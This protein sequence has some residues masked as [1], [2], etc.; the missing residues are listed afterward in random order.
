MNDIEKQI[1]EFFDRCPTRKQIHAL[2]KMYKLSEEKIIVILSQNGKV[3]PPREEKPKAKGT[4]ANV[5]IVD[6][7][8]TK[9]LEN[10]IKQPES[11]IKSQYT[12]SEAI[13]K[14]PDC[15]TNTIERRMHEL[16]TDIRN[17]QDIVQ[18]LEAEYT[19]HAD[20][21]M[22]CPFEQRN[23]SHCCSDDTVESPQP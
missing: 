12:K 22:N 14:M 20:Y 18:K 8:A 15:V 2:A 23:L 10:V 3:I 5:I 6:E 13:I 9:D 21:L 16:E 1:I 7:N 4:K 11:I 17:Y 19:A